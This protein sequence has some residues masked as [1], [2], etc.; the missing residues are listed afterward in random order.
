M[1]LFQKKT[2][3]LKIGLALGGGGAR[4]LAHIQVLETLDELGI[5]P[6]KISGTSIGAVMGALYASGLSGKEI[7][8]LV[9]EWQTP[10][11]EKKHGFLNRHDLRRW[12]ALF[13]P[14]FDR[15]GLFKGEKIIRFLSDYIKYETFE[16]LKIPL[17]VTSADYGD[18]SEVV[19]NSGDLLSAVRASIAIPG[20]FTPVELNG[21][22]L[23]DGGIVN[24][25]PYDLIQNE[26]DVVI[27]V[28]VGGI[29]SIGENS[30]PTFFETVIGSFEIVQA[31]LISY[32]QKF[33]PPH[34]YLK[35]EI[36]DIG[37]LDFHK[38]DLIFK[39]SAPIKEELRRRLQETLKPV[40]SIFS[41]RGI[42]TRLQ[43][44]RGL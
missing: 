24:P 43:A 5:R 40:D 39:Q 18:A 8:E 32:H 7:R 15:S 4:G 19:F 36:R 10:R 41:A 1:K 30:R 9:H 38:A 12:A 6:C 28:D 35:P 17:T 42:K 16:D 44:C 27:A 37:L 14:S 26:C 11:P 3:V 34:I 20:V 33:N 25:L 22:L 23:L 29:R 2:K 31:S 13:D 21:R